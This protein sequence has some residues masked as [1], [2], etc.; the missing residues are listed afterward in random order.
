MRYRLATCLLLVVAVFGSS[1]TF[2][3]DRRIRLAQSQALSSCLTSC[4]TQIVMCQF[5]CI[6]LSTGATTSASVTVVGSTTNPTQC[7][8]NCTTQQQVCQ[9]N[10][11]RQQQ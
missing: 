3:A 4:S 6:N 2:S 9:Q 10:C 5:T 11:I 8:L 1:E 7:S